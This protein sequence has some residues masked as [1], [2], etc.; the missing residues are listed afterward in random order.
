MKTESKCEICG[1]AAMLHQVDVMMS[2]NTACTDFEITPISVCVA[3][4]VN[5][6][7]VDS[8]GTER[9]CAYSLN[10]DRRIIGFA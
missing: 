3:H 7:D 8:E 10:N 2:T 9:D 5:L 4:S 1:D 6:F